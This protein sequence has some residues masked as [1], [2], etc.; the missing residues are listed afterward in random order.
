MSFLKSLDFAN[1]EIGNENGVKIGSIFNTTIVQNAQE[2]Q[3]FKVEK[4]ILEEIKQAIVKED[5]IMGKK[6]QKQK[7]LQSY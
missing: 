1:K 4:E 5:Q 2:K 6:A 7:V 3:S